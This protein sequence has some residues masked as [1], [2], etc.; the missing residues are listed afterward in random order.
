MFGAE[1]VSASGENALVERVRRDGRPAAT[2]DKQA[3]PRQGVP[4]RIGTAS[5]FLLRFWIKAGNG[6]F[7]WQIPDDKPGQAGACIPQRFMLE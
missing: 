5:G 1:P 6:P 2:G 7:M 3:T 4:G